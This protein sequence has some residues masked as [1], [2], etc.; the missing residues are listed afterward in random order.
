MRTSMIL[1]LLLIVL[2]AQAELFRNAYVSFELP[3]NWSC[4]LEKTEWVCTSKYAK[5]VK[6]AIIVLTAKEAGPAD[7]LAAYKA[8]LKT[9]RQVPNKKGSF[10]KSKI[11]SVTEKT[12]GGHRWVDG[13]HEGSEIASYYTR[14]LATV[15]DR[16]AI[17][18]SFSAHKAHYTKYSNDFLKSVNSLKVIATKDLLG[19]RP[20]T[21]SRSGQREMIGGSIDTIPVGGDIAPPA[22]KKSNDLAIKLIA[23]ALIM[24]AITLLLLRK[25]K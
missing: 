24:G 23:L 1:L 25:K 12:L 8:K 20:N 15:K 7:S 5:N 11:H 13:L 16:L 18:V 19:Q 10:V 9:P 14:Y 22:P 6:E 2:P 17:L 4:K 3:P 21:R